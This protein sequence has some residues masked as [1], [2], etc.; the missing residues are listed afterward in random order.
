MKVCIAEKPSVAREIAEVLGATK[1]MNGYM[2][3]NGYQVTWT[4]GHLCTLKE[5]NDY[6]DNW[7][8]WSLASL[9]MIP[10]RF[11]IKLISNPTYEQQFKTIEELMQKA[12]KKKKIMEHWQAIALWLVLYDVVAVNAAFM[13]AL[14]VRFDCR[15][16]L[17]PDVYLGAFLKFAPWYT[18][19]SIVVYWA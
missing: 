3:G 2:E 19:V 7:K 11:G 18:I 8:R 13:L 12:G 1:K 5:P 17:I 10:P 14:W 16:S 6:S 15:Y 4:F 9:P